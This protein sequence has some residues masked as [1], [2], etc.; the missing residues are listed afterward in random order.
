MRSELIK[1]AMALADDRPLPD[2]GIL[3]MYNKET[4]NAIIQMTIDTVKTVQHEAVFKDDLR[5]STDCI[6]LYNKMI[7]AINEV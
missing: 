4:I 5:V 6:L 1:L 7:E 2:G 3:K